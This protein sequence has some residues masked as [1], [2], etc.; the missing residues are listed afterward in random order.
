MTEE[1]P[2]TTIPPDFIDALIAYTID[3]SK[4]ENLVQELE[5]RDDVLRRMDP[6]EFLAALSRAEALAWELQQSGSPTDAAALSPRTDLLLFGATGT[7]LAITNTPH[8]I[9]LTTDP[10]AQNL[11]D[12]LATVDQGGPHALATLTTRTGAQR[13]GYILP[14]AKLPSGFAQLL[15]AEQRQNANF[16]MLVPANQPAREACDVLQA[17]FNLTSAERSICLHLAAGEQ[18]KEAAAGLNISVNTARNQLQSVFEKTGL[19]RQKDLLL[20]LTQM[21]VIVSAMRAQEAA[22]VTVPAAAELPSLQ[23]SIIAL[24]AAPRRMAYRCYG[25]GRRN[26]L[27]FHESC[28]TSRLT[29]DTT[30]LAN[31]LDLRI[32]AAER[33]GAGFSDPHEGLSFES[34]ARDMELLLKD[35][36]IDKVSLLGYMA[37]GAYALSTALKLR[38]RVEHLMLVSGRAPVAY[39]PEGEHPLAILRRKLAAQPWLHRAFFNILRSRSGPAT[40][41]R[42]LNRLYGAVARDAA[43]LEAHPEILDHMVAV[44]MESLTISAAG[45]ANEVSCFTRPGTTKLDRLACRVSVWH[46][47]ADVVAPAASLTDALRDLSF[48]RRT[49]EGWGSMIRLRLLGGNPRSSCSALSRV[50]AREDQALSSAWA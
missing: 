18:L 23:F 44:T 38:E 49:F 10:N 3:P 14:I 45:L 5:A 12:A 27:F 16:A 48:E 21:S 34:V 8:D 22:P 2:T 13:F 30:R 25:E 24:E 32:I 47:D 26:V 9:D 40:N 29:A 42:I 39:D 4:W 19:N 46:G 31:T 1:S 20:L 7:P 33:P 43:Y 6:G 41:R 37:G 28:A 17:S 11:G 35:L 15:T 50:G 36:D